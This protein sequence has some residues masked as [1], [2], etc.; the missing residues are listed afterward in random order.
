LFILDQKIKKMFFVS[1]IFLTI[2]IPAIQSKPSLKLTIT[3]DEK[4]YASGR[5]VDIQCEIIN[6]NDNT[7]PPQL[8]H[9]DFKTGRHTIVSRQLISSPPDDSPDVFKQ[10]KPK[11]Y[12]Y[13]RKNYIR[14]NNVQLEDSA[15]YECN[16]PDCE[17]SLGKLEKKFQVIKLAEPKLNFEPGWPIQEHAKTIIKCIADDFYPYVG[18][19]IIRHHHDITKDG[20]SV[21]PTGDTYPQKFSWEGTF[22]PTYEWHN[23]TLR[24]TV[25]EGLFL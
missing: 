6:P 17:E 12:E 21:V 16:C 3:P 14:I 4:Y 13:M 19:R 1:I 24:C 23:T 10:V 7:E 5:S 20:K 25:H 15:Q 8:W 2:L 9:V 11:R 18:H 22:T